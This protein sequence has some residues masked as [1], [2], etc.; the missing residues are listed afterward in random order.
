MNENIE[1][2]DAE[3]EEH[4]FVEKAKKGCEFCGNRIPALDNNG[5]E[6]A[7]IISKTFG[8]RHEWNPLVLCPRCHKVLDD[9][10]KPRILKAL[11]EAATG[12]PKNGKTNVTKFRIADNWSELV[13][14]LVT[15]SG[16][17]W[18]LEPIKS[19]L[20]RWTP[21]ATPASA[22]QEP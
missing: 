22:E 7:H 3:T 4:W 18:P 10:V 19:D 12:F 2:A 8:P 14:T 17:P 11:N 5:L 21:P 15:K 9:V 1:K 13:S 6:K 20:P 16:K